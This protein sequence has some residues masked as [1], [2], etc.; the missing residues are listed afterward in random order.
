MPKALGESMSGR[1][2][3]RALFHDELPDRMPFVPMMTSYFWSTLPVEWQIDNAAD[4]CRRVGSDLFDWH[5]PSYKGWGYDDP[6]VLATGAIKRREFAHND[7]TIVE[8]E[9]P[10]GT[11]TERKRETKEAG[12]TSFCLE[13]LIK[14]IDDLPAYQHLWEAHSPRA[15]YELTMERIAEVGE[16]GLVAV[17]MPPT[18]LLHLI[19]RDAGLDV[20]YYLLADHPRRMA[21]LLRAMTDKLLALCEV[22]AAAPAEVAVIAENSGTRLVSPRQFAAHCVPVVREYT[23]LLHA[24]GKVALLHAC[25]HIRDLLGGI[26][27]TGVDGIESLTPPPTGNTTLRD[28]RE[29]LGADKIL[30]GGLDPMLFATAP[31]AELEFQVREIA[32][33]VRPG[34]NFALMPADSCQAGAPL[35]SFSVVRRAI[36]HYARWR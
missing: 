25:G 6:D 24:G 5:V 14:S 3:L 2:S 35:A 13:H 7:M 17:R 18:P 30:I 10:L 4:A 8:Y 21:K 34:R 26:A 28:A 12:K 16:D 20:T 32:A 29:I 23:R 9:T 15:A 36:E 27:D 1:E 11:L 33:E 22:V 31:P 19:M